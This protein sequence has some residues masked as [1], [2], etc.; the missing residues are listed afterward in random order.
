MS[1]SGQMRPAAGLLAVT[2][3]DSADLSNGPA[4]ALYVGT[5]G[6]IAVIMADGTSGT[7]RSAAAGYHPLQVRR[8][9]TTGT[10]ES[11]ILALY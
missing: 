3:S 6:D 1:N 5:S 11:N 8:V 4:R 7:I 9:K 10:T 2:P